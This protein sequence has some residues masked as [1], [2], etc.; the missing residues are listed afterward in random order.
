MVSSFNY[1]GFLPFLYVATCKRD[2]LN[3]KNLYNSEK[4][5][6]KKKKKDPK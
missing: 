3:Y 4:K 6:K 2:N 5:E 1:V